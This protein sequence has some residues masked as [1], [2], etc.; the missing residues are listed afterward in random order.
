MTNH[1]KSKKSTFRYRRY[2]VHALILL[3][4][5]KDFL[6]KHQLQYIL[7]RTKAR[8]MNDMMLKTPELLFYIEHIKVMFTF[9]KK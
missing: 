4:I 5:T 1:L 3:E 9:V 7:E 8:T 6:K 2:I